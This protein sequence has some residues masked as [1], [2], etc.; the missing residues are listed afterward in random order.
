MP[1]WPFP[2]SLSGRALAAWDIDKIL[3]FLQEALDFL[4][5]EEGL[6]PSISLVAVLAHSPDKAKEMARKMKAIDEFRNNYRL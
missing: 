2:A 4:V 6:F 5:R 3:G 1:G